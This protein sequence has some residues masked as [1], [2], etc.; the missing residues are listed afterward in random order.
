MQIVGTSLWKRGNNDVTVTVQIARLEPLSLRLLF[1]IPFRF[2]L[3][4]L[5][6]SISLVAIPHVRTPIR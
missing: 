1:L 5:S 4:P 3:C 6:L 2:I